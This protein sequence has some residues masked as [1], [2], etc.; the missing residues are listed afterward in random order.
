M[1]KDLALLSLRLTLGSIF[2]VHACDKIG[3]DSFWMLW[4][5]KDFS[6]HLS[7]AIQAFAELVSNLFSFLS[8]KQAYW[9]ASATV[10]IELMGGWCLVMGVAGRLA[11]L[12]LSLMMCGA[13]YYH[14]PNGFYANEGGYQWAMLCLGASL[15][16]MLQGVGNLSLAGLLRAISAG[17]SRAL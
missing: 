9:L 14:L 3:L 2:I 8:P 6:T 4:E 10:G 13:I 1:Q 11:G 12:L 7:I 5:I 17:Q 15:S 16:V